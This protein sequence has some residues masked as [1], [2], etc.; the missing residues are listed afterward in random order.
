VN[1]VFAAHPD[2]DNVSYVGPSVTGSGLQIL[3]LLLPDQSRYSRPSGG[4]PLIVWIEN[5]G[6]R[7][8]KMSSTLGPQTLYLNT[9]DLDTEDSYA[10]Q[11]FLYRAL[12][13]GWAVAF[14]CTT[15]AF[16][17]DVGNGTTL[18]QTDTLIDLEYV[19]GKS[20]LDYDFG[21]APDGNGVFIPYY[22]GV[23]PTGYKDH[24]GRTEAQGAIH[25]YQDPRRHN[26]YM[27]SEMI[28]QYIRANAEAMGIDITR[29][30]GAGD[31]GGAD[32]SAWCVYGP[33][34]ATTRWLDPQ[35][36]E[37]LDTR[38]YRGAFYKTWQPYFDMV[39]NAYEDP[40][41]CCR[42]PKYTGGVTAVHD[43]DAHYDVPG[44]S[45]LNVRRADI[46]EG[47]AMTWYDD[48]AIASNLCFTYFTS[49]DGYNSGSGIGK[50]P[51]VTPVSGGVAPI[52]PSLQPDPHSSYGLGLWKELL[53]DNCIAYLLTGVGIAAT[54]EQAALGIVS[55]DESTSGFNL[56]HHRILNFLEG[57]CSVERRWRFNPYVSRRLRT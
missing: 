9:S 20:S 57:D 36:Q 32:I 40:A 43:L 21:A 1:T 48:D 53:G 41:G 19:I 38:I 34:R 39:S 29:V 14:C 49:L 35:G 51:W 12:L 30:Y 52:A 8:T 4:W 50:G 27:D 24:L 37:N 3:T 45:I 11:L 56:L 16:G 28:A 26:C 6:F 13:R 5:G 47:D 46:R 25:P 33:N 23:F 55:Y 7:F 2:F 42:S 22:G 17:D 31:S 44:D 54:A 18:G 10:S 15:V